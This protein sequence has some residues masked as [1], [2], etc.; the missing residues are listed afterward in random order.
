MKSKRFREFTYFI[1]GH[2]CLQNK[3][4]QPNICC[5]SQTVCTVRTIYK[6]T[7]TISCLLKYF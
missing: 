2:I 1:Y 7:K 3:V 4:N 5:D 6:V